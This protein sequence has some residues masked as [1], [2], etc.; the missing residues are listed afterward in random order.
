[1]SWA[2]SA[3]QATSW[4]SIRELPGLRPG[5]RLAVL[6]RGA[7]G[8]VMSSNYNA[9]A[10]A[11]EVIVDQVRGGWSSVREWRSCSEGEGGM[12]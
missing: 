2:R 9:R 4:H 6:V 8:F 11:A 12:E 7:Y 3:R 5:E 10:R 1:M